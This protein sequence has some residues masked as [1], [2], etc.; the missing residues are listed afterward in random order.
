M[1]KVIILSEFD[2][3]YITFILFSVLDKSR[4]LGANSSKLE[5]M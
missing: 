2:Q 5:H 3:L 1:N 4:N